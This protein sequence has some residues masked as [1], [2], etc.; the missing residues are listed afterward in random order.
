MS[1]KVVGNRQRVRTKED[2]QGASVADMDLFGNRLRLPREIQEE[3]DRKGLKH[4]FVSIKLIQ[5][6]GGYHPKGWTPYTL[7]KSKT[8]PITGQTE[9][10]FRVGDLILAV[11]PAAEHAKHLNWLQQKSA[12]QSKAHKNSIR[13]MRDRIRE[14]RADKHIA[15]IEGF[16]ENE[17]DD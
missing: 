10:T 14:G 5:E 1:D 4:R 12:A 16:E 13:E 7:E 3:L 17:S 6:S 2:T 15:L 8:N 9:N 11:K